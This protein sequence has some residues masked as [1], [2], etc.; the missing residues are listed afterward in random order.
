MIQIIF[1]FTAT[2]ENIRLASALFYFDI[3]FVKV[4]SLSVLRHFYFPRDVEMSIYFAH[5]M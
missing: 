3:C 2:G 4:R 5:G 1:Y